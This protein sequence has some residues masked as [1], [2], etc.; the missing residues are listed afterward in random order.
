[1]TIDEPPAAEHDE[2][3]P[4]KYVAFCDVLG[5]SHA[6]ENDFNQTIQVYKAF[7]QRTNHQ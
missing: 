3:V 6:V 4:M 5:F 1:M 7:Q 2:P